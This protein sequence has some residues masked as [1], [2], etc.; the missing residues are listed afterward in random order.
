MRDFYAD[1]IHR[2]DLVFD[3]GANVGI[4]SEIFTELGANVIAIEP[5][6]YCT[7]YYVGSRGTT[8]SRL[9]PV[10]SGNFPGE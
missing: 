3:V 10:L 4:Y 2:G 8:R 7:S 1:Y 5:K 6:P 9:R